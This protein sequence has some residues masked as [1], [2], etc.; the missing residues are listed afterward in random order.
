VT[1]A[2]AACGVCSENQLVNRDRGGM[3]EIEDPLEQFPEDRRRLLMISQTAAAS[4]DIYY[5]TK[6]N[7]SHPLLQYSLTHQVLEALSS[8][9]HGMLPLEFAD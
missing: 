1:V 4:Y 5:L 9:D 3:T 2:F 7:S 6:T 8:Q